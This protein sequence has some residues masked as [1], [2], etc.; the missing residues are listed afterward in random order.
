MGIYALLIAGGNFL[1][2]LLM[3]FVNEGQNWQWVLVG[4]S[5]RRDFSFYAQMT[6]HPQALVFNFHRRCN[7]N[8]VLLHG[9]DKLLSRRAF[10]GLT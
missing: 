9:G 10:G 8:C 7:H 2:P 3:G 1:A 6:N 4:A 5:P